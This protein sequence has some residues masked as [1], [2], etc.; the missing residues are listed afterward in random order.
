ML[1]IMATTVPTTFTPPQAATLTELYYATSETGTALKQVFGV[2]AIPPAIT[3]KE[4]ITYRTLE[5]DVEFSVKGVR[6][7][8]SI[9]V[10]CILFKEQF[11]EIKTLADAGDE[12]WWFVKLPDA[13]K[14]VIKWRGGVDISV[15]EI[16]LDDMLKS[17]IKIGKTTVPVMLEALPTTI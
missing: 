4:D 10:E 15:S 17:V 9:E 5:S 14:M 6:P 7:Y 2:Q 13:L 11:T 16:A 1:Q 8:E 12:L 3:A